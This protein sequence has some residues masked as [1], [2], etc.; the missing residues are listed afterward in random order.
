MVLPQHGGGPNSAW[1]R[2]P[3]L[4][5]GGSEGAL[6][7]D[8]SPPRGLSVFWVNFVIYKGV[9]VKLENYGVSCNGIL[10]PLVLPS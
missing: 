3:S 10:S 6:P 7:L 2:M 9:N 5:D 1:R 4:D 8:G